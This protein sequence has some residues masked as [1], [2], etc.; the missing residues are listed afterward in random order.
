MGFFRQ[1]YWIGLPFL[2]LRDLPDPGIEP[3]SLVS[4]ELQVDSLPLSHQ[5]QVFKQYKNKT[6]VIFPTL[7]KAVFCAVPEEPLKLCLFSPLVIQT[8]HVLLSSHFWTHWFRSSSKFNLFLPWLYSRNQYLRLVILARKTES[9]IVPTSLCWSENYM[10]WQ[11]LIQSSVP[12]LHE[13][14][15]WK[16][17]SYVQLFATPW[18]VQSMEF[19]RSECCR[20]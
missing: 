3:T 20:G 4:P 7:S 10:K 18:T 15:K 13:K 14:W 12:N 17:F 11:T 2:P 19:S 5:E 1:E 16:S 9:I 8:L 6:G